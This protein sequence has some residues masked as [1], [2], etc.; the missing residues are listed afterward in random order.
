MDCNA[1]Y[2]DVSIYIEYVKTFRCNQ[3]ILSASLQLKKDNLFYAL[4]HNLWVFLVATIHSGAILSSYRPNHNLIFETGIK[5]VKPGNVN[6]K[7]IDSLYSLRL[8]IWKKLNLNNQNVS[9][10][11]ITQKKC[12]GNT[13]FL[14]ANLPIL[15]YNS[16]FFVVAKNSIKVCIDFTQP[17]Q[18]VLYHWS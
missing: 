9:K 18:I 5:T 17:S 10:N 16:A 14:L 7:S 6:V 15:V 11:E 2:S 3:I 12:S 13:N 8:Y 4:W 1:L